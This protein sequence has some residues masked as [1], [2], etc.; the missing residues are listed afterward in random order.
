MAELAILVTSAM[1]PSSYTLVGG[2]FELYGRC[3]TRI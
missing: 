1:V 3:G 2:A